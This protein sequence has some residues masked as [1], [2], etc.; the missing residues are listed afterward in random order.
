MEESQQLLTS[1]EEEALTERIRQM[2]VTGHSLT[3]NLIHKIAY[4]FRQYRLIGINDEEIPHV[5]YL[6]LSVKTR[7]N[8][9]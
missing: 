2:T 6:S 9:S 4:K 7:L 3:Q 8:D 1:T 5:K